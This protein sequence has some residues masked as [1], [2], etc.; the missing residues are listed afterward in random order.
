VGAKN[1][2]EQVERRKY[3][4]LA[5]Q[6]IIKC[7]PYTI[8]AENGHTK[9]E[10]LSKNIS[11][12]GILFEAHRHYAIGDIIRIEITIPGWDKYKPEFYKTQALSYSQPLVTLGSVVRVE[13]VTENIY[14]IGVCLIGIDEKHQMALEKYIAEQRKQL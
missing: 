3:V 6:H 13:L 14:D 11:A 9:E 1:K 4:R 12:G 7:E 2:S 10:L 5:A 8:P